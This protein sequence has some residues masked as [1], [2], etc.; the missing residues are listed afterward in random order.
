MPVP[1]ADKSPEAVTFDD[2]QNLATNG[3][4]RTALDSTDVL[5]MQDAARYAQDR[6]G[7]PV[8]PIDVSRLDDSLFNIDELNRKSFDVY[9]GTPF[10]GGTLGSEANAAAAESP[11]LAGI[12][13]YMAKDPAY[14]GEG[15]TFDMYPDS[16][17]YLSDLADYM[18]HKNRQR[19]AH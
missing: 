19:S 3:H 15:Y 13:D 11:Y 10:F 16:D 2:I 8:I 12:L 18:V 5:P 7:R 9:R 1:F 4:L 14:S 6:V 17:K